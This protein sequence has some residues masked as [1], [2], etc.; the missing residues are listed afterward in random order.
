MV[1]S[2]LS[3]NPALDGVDL[4]RR[5][6]QAAR[7]G[8]L[9]DPERIEAVVDQFRDALTQGLSAH[10]TV[11][12]WRAQALFAALVAALDGCDL[13]TFTDIGEIYA[14]G[15]A[16]KA[17][18]FFL[19]LRDGRRLL[20][21][22]KAVAPARLATATFKFGRSEVARLREFGDRFGAEVFIAIFLTPLS[23]W[24]LISIDDLTD[25]PSGAYS[26]SHEEAN[27][28]NQMALLGDLWIGVQP[29]LNLVLRPD[30]QARTIVEPDGN[31]KFQIR[32]VERWAGGRQIHGARES[33]IHWLLWLYG[34]WESTP[35]AELDGD[36]FL[37]LHHV[38]EPPE[39]SDDDWEIIGPLSMMFS[40]LFEGATRGP[41][42]V[43]AAL[44]MPKNPGMLAALIPDDYA[45]EEL[46]LW[47]LELVKPTP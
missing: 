43:P 28:V 33:Q 8:P 13:M 19:H 23:R 16:V 36:Q 37:G 14:D 22:V 18:D 1:L 17:P 2:P 24:Y 7:T 15:A 32:A 47:R 6:D 46:P 21:D 20:V 41:D 3:R 4:F 26:I 27:I 30:P 45:S 44:D 11:D 9:T 35:T 25:R 5:L 10:S 40:R 38:A 39:R 29:P 42:G 34:D 12:G 31:V